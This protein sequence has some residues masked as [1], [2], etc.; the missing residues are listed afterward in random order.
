MS[1]GGSKGRAKRSS[2]G[3]ALDVGW[4]IERRGRGVEEMQLSSLQE[5]R[6]QL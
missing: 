4:S 6:L 2:E 3:R 5:R 1:V